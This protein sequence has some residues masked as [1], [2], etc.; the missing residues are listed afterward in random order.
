MS[1]RVLRNRTDLLAPYKWILKRPKS[2]LPSFVL[3]NAGGRAPA[4]SLIGSTGALYCALGATHGN[5]WEGPRCCDRV[6][7]PGCGG[8]HP[9]ETGNLS[10]P[11]DL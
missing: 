6:E 4:R 9:V 11:G 7:A 10:S 8:F 5:I 2:Q 3:R 1:S